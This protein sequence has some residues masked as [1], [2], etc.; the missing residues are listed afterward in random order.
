MAINSALM[1]CFGDD[2]QSYRGL[3]YGDVLSVSLDYR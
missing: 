1:R 2:W 3:E